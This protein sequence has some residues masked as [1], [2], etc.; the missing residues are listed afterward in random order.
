MIPPVEQAV[1]PA[2]HHADQDSGNQ[3]G[4][5]GRQGIKP[6]Q[7]RAEGIHAEALGKT[8]GTEY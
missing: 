8:G 6:H 4:G 2:R 5:K 3:A 1:Q 7:S